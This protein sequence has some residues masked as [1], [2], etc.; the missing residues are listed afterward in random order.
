VD[1]HLQDVGY[2]KRAQLLT[3]F[4]QRVRNGGFGSGREVKGDTVAMALSSVGTEITMVC[5]TNPL[6]VVGTNNY[7]P[8]VEQTFNGWQKTDHPVEKKLPVEVDVP[9]LLV[10]MALM[11]GVLE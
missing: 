1:P 5:G 8:R 10:R 2:Q 4:A 3:G 9:E 7:I 11:A 6:K